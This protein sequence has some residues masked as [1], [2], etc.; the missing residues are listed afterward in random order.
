MRGGGALWDNQG[1]RAGTW[2][3][4]ASPGA[5]PR[6][7]VRTRAKGPVR[8]RLHPQNPRGVPAGHRWAFSRGHQA[9]PAGASPGL[10]SAGHSPGPA[11]D[12]APA[13]APP[14]APPPTGHRV[15]QGLRGGRDG[16]GAGGSA[17]WAGMEL[18]YESS[19]ARGAL[20][21]GIC[22]GSAPAPGAGAFL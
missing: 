7:G 4:A 8:P 14:L 20:S 12:V 9:L 15:Q 18:E 19:D 1:P 10:S 13:Q 21:P 5:A 16:A 11:P 2:V 6:L 22:L 3:G 17:W